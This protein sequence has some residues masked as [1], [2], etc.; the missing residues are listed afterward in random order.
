MLD[1]IYGLSML[2]LSR[3]DIDSNSLNFP[4]HSG[5][6]DQLPAVVRSRQ[7]L[8]A[9]CQGSGDEEHRRANGL[10]LWMRSINNTNRL[11]LLNFGAIMDL[12]VNF[13]DPPIRKLL[14]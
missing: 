4:V 12:I 1:A 5:K 2:A 9:R 8:P 6:D 13:L 14:L 10:C 11:I 7:C 3:F